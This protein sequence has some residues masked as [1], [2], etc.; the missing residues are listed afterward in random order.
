[1]RL[2]RKLTRDDD[3]DPAAEV[4]EISSA[5]AV[6]VPGP[7][8]RVWELVHDPSAAVGASDDVVNAWREAGSP[9]GLGE[10]QVYETATPEGVLRFRYRATECEWGSRAVSE[11]VQL[12]PGAARV[13]TDTDLRTLDDGTVEVTLRCWMLVPGPVSA[14]EVAE[15]QR[16]QDEEWGRAKVRFTAYLERRRATEG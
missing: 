8:S 5:F 6:V 12:R 2:G 14:D 11:M 16:L 9:V 13:G 3:P 4:V 7:Q 1:M 15:F 10:I